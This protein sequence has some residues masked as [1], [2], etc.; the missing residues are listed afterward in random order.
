M[1]GFVIQKASGI[2][3]VPMPTAEVVSSMAGIK[4]PFKVDGVDSANYSLT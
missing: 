1:R 2:S 4:S 3:F